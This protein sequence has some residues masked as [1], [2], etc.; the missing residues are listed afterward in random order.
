[1]NA[2]IADPTEE[3]YGYAPK[4]VAG[5]AVGRRG[6]RGTAILSEKTHSIVVFVTR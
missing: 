6:N 1:M 2:E 3:R 4:T 5:R